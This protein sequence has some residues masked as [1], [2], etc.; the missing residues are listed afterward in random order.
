MRAKML[1][2]LTSLPGA[3][4]LALW[5]CWGQ[6]AELQVVAIKAVLN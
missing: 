6:N 3:L 5:L 1:I 2:C 4:S